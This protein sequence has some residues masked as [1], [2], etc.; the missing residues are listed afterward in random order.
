MVH[1]SW[2]EIRQSCIYYLFLFY[3]A[4]LEQEVF[5]DPL[6]EVEGMRLS[7]LLQEIILGNHNYFYLR[8]QEL[9]FDFRTKIE[10]SI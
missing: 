10:N 1:R 3:D 2:K 6:L 4:C 9:M 5:L 8:V 7:N